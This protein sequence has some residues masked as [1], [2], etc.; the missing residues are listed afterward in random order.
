[1]TTPPTT[2]D[3]DHARAGV[4]GLIVLVPHTHWDR[5]WY[6]PL[7]VFRERLLELFDGLLDIM[8]SEPRFRHFHLDGQSAMIDDYLELRPDR[9]AELTSLFRSG[10]LSVGPW[11]TQADE[12]LTSGE[13][14]IRNLEWG[15]VRARS[16]GLTDPVGGPWAGYLPDQFGH[17]GQ[18][19]QL[20]RRAGIDRAVVLRGVPAAIDRGTFRWRAP[21]GSEVL[22]EYLM[23]GYYLGA[24]L[25][26][27][28]E[29]ADDLATE[30][31]RV[32][33]TVA[34]ITDRDRTLV[35]V[36]SDHTTPVA[37]LA[38]LVDEAA[39]IA[40]S[41][42]VIGSVAEFLRDAP[43]PAD[44]PVWTGEL[45]AASHWPLLPNVYGTRPAQKRRRARLE[46]RL[47][48][49]AE[50][51]AALVPG[52][53]WPA[54]EL[55]AAW[56]RLLW[57][58][59]HDSA[60]GCVH[61][62][63]A[64]DVDARNDQVE[65][66]TERVIARAAG[67]LADGARG[68]GRLRWNPSPF[69]REGIPGL[70]W[71]VVPDAQA[72]APRPVDVDIE[73]EDIVLAL[74]GTR[75]S[76]TD[77]PD[78]GD[79]YTFCP[80]DGAGPVAP[81]LLEMTGPGRVLARFDGVTPE[82][83]VELGLTH[84]PDEPFV[85]LDIRID[86]RRP[87]HRL[88]LHVALGS[89]PAGSTALAPFEVVD[90]PLVGEGYEQESGSPTWPARGLA[91]AAGTAVLAEGVFEYEVDGSSLAV[92]LLRSVGL[93]ARPTLP[94]RP[95]WAGP[96]TPTPEAQCLGETRL[97]LGVWRGATRE[98]LVEAWERFALPILEVPATGEG[99]AP[100]A[101]RLVQLEGA[102]LSSARR[103]DGALEIRIWND[104]PEPVVAR[105]AG[106]DVDLGPAEIRAIRLGDKGR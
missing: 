76:L 81:T 15:R 3:R 2:L 95:V 70:G 61:D 102:Q 58:G 48:R 89:R 37:R 41:E 55:E 103:I 52:V 19:P 98:R 105:L 24:D 26:D 96:A 91:L 12:F 82:L 97:S 72:E 101:A 57:N 86:N 38:E 85:R 4:P 9:E 21:D 49:Y 34:A 32:A 23:H 46:A 42:V 87:D 60:Y 90:R 77:E 16:L 36:G 45:R 14:T 30:L 6:E 62:Q 8:A 63:V 84:R 75:I 13:S 35:M 51:L 29:D 66:I 25:V 28:L 44:V 80:L 33:T 27:H 104:R 47:E 22:A 43:P 59:A 17:I 79:L 50:P 65:A 100:A 53:D 10:R 54:E 71:Q 56:R 67:R 40:G 74:D 106:A 69:E 1:M 31:I 92:T 78:I 68:P 18:M 39:G 20:L 7:P 94:T 73:G 5:E 64:R 88:R 11:F 99:S 83:I 93:I